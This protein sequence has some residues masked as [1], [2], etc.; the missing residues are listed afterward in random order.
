M[1]LAK[2][3]SIMNVVGSVR[4]TSTKKMNLQKVFIQGLIF[5]ATS[6][7][8]ATIQPPHKV[9]IS[10]IADHPALDATTN[11][12]VAALEIKGYKQGKNLDLRI[13]SA[14]GNPALAQ[15]IAAKYSNQNPAVVVGVG[16]VTA[17]SF[18][19]HAASKKVKLVFSSITDPLKSGLVQTITAPNNNTSGVSN[20]IDLLP[21][22]ELFKKLQPSLKKLG[23]LYN[24]G[25]A[26]SVILKEKLEELC[27]QLDLILICQAVNKTADVAQNATKLAQNSQAI[28]I[29]N[30]STALSSLQSVIKAATRAK[31]PV[32]VSDT[33]A[34]AL[35]AVAALGPN[36]YEIGLQTGYMIA[37][38]LNGG[39]IAVEQIELPHK[40]DLYLNVDA[41]AR[42]GIIIPEE[43]TKLATKVIGGANS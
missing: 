5:I 37:R 11:G 2:L 22:L 7:Q 9:Y 25:E 34:V 26:N 12:I 24:P 40:T 41:A 36:Q 4:L 14:Q 10:K 19:K 20:Y 21:Q 42:I 33:D 35:G 1:E 3:I 23:F 15:Q 27:P 32:Y 17:Q 6:A 31:I 29:S 38:L 18:A 28:F 39:D 8:S 30:D 16:T 13:E 43:L